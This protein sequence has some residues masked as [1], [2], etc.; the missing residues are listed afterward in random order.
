MSSTGDGRLRAAITS[1]VLALSAV[2][3][4]DDA[5]DTYEW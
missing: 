1:V 4:L 5:L 2:Y 3:G